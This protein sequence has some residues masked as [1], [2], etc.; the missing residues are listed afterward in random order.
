MFHPEPLQLSLESRIARG[1][2]QDRAQEFLAPI[3]C[4][5]P[6]PPHGLSLSPLWVL[7]L[8]HVILSTT[9]GGCRREEKSRK[10]WSFFTMLLF[11]VTEFFY[12]FVK[13]K[14]KEK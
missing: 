7:L 1:W 3:Q 6:P 4:E 5:N 11:S 8:G 12:F 14:T 9:N 13:L 2:A 10:H